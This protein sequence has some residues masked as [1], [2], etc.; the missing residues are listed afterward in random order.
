M[1]SIV[2]RSLKSLSEAADRPHVNEPSCSGNICKRFP[3]TTHNGAII[4]N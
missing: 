2:I 4:D 3:Q 1:H